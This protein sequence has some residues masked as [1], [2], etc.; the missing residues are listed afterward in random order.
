MPYTL[1][2]AP[3][4][5]L[6]WVVAE[7]GQKKSK[8]PLPRARAEAQMRALY[9]VMRKEGG[10]SITKKDFVKEHSHLVDVLR[11]G[12]VAQRRKEAKD[13]AKE[14]ALKGGCDTCP[15]ALVER[16]NKM[17]PHLFG[18]MKQRFYEDMEDIKTNLYGSGAMP[19]NNVLQQMAQ[20]SYKPSPDQKV[21]GWTLVK[22]TPTLK[23]YQLG[24]TIIVAIRGTADQRDVSTWLPSA[25]GSL[26]QSDRF[27]E[28]LATL[29]QF[30]N[31]FPPDQFDYYGVGHSLGGAILDAFLNAGLLKK[32][33]SY[34]PAVAV[35]NFQKDTGNKRIYNEDDP[36]YNTLGRFTK[37]P[38][39]RKAKPKSFWESMVS[40]VPYLGTAWKGY[41]SYKAHALKNFIGGSDHKMN[42]MLDKLLKA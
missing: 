13:Q 19:D 27:K 38:E 6:Y 36:L 18:G 15:D 2:K 31:Q 29:T 33:V 1:R 32:G 5:D 25:L 37:N 34:N 24:D 30:K 10:V 40:Q 21:D 8:E 35:E 7:D 41:N 23:M 42:K 22:S 12:T 16:M 14:L 4:R 3:N 20:Q 11:H 39:V 28:D 9:S 17:L 26:E